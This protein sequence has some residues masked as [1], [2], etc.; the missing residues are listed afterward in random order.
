[1]GWKRLSASCL[2]RNHVGDG[3]KERV[4]GGVELLLVNRS[5]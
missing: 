3:V 2:S 4:Q 5:N 1:M